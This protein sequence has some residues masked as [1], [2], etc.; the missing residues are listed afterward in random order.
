MDTLVFSQGDF[1]MVFGEDK[2]KVLN[3]VK[4]NGPHFKTLYSTI[5]QECP[6]VVYK[7][8]QG[9]LEV[10]HTT[11][12]IA[13]TDFSVLVFMEPEITTKSILSK[14]ICKLVISN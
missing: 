1:R 12:T 7:P 8:Q 10:R 4:D 5:L 2:S 3:I 13:P 11:H 9:R 6:Q 14:I